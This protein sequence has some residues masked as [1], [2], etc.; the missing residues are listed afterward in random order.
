MAG[1][2]L[3]YPYELVGG[4][5]AVASEVMGNFYAIQTAMAGVNTEI[6]NLTK[7][8]T[9][10][11]EKPTSEMMSILY[12][13]EAV[14]PTGAFPLWTGQTLTNAKTLYP[15]FWKKLNDMADKGQVKTVADNAAYETKLEQFGQ[16]AAFYIDKLNGHIRLPKVTRF[17][18]SIAD[19]NEVGEVNAGLPNITGN[20]K[21]LESVQTP[22][23]SNG[24]L[25]AIYNGQSGAGGSGGRHHNIEISLDASKSNSVYGNSNTVQPAAVRIYCYLQVVNNTAEIS[26]FDVDA[27]A[28]QL[29][30]ALSELQTKYDEYVTRLQA[31]FDRLEEFTDV[32]T[33]S[34]VDAK[35]SEKAG[36]VRLSFEISNNSWYRRLNYDGAY[37]YE[38]AF[39]VWENKV[40]IVPK[41]IEL[42]FRE[43]EAV[44]G[45]YSP[46]CNGET[47]SSGR[48]FAYIY[49]KKIPEKQLYVDVVVIY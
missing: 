42:I 4:T 28:T 23:S 35:I 32:Y 27:L 45:N 22:P 6:N 8:L 34:E 48:L 39:K 26:R 17:I 1:T 46:T 16:C 20:I 31:E 21:Y 19:L 47:T 36:V 30:E 13:F 40:G 33:K 9:E 38:A 41:S 24:A 15:E 12:R 7:V 49:A 43:E 18:S 11:K 10:L 25:K 44:S 14:A 37:Q 3:V 5:K 29:N 2:T